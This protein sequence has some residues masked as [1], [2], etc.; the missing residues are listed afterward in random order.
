MRH[1]C[2]SKTK[3]K[4]RADDNEQSMHL[5]LICEMCALFLHEAD[6]VK[7]QIQINC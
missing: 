6:M 3:K 7:G 5:A 4:D 1:L 2:F